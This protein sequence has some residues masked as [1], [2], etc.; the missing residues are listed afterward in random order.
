MNI[1]HRW[2]PLV[3]VG[4]CLAITATTWSACSAQP[5]N[6]L[7][8]SER[9]FNDDPT[10]VLVTS[11]TANTLGFP[12]I[13]SISDAFSG[14]VSGTNRHDFLLS[15]DGGSSAH[16]F[17]I[18]DTFTLE[19]EV[20]LTAGANAPRKEAGLRLNSGIGDAL[21]L[22]N[23]DA[24][25][26]VAF[27]GP[28]FSFGSN[29]GG[30]GYSPGDTILLGLTYTGGGDGVG[31]TPS[32]IEFYIDRLD[33]SGI[34]SSGPL[35]FTNLEGGLPNFTAGLYGQGGTLESTAPGDFLNVVFNDINASVIPE[36]ASATILGLV[37]CV[38]V[39]FVRRR[40]A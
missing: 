27:G 32:T 36:P 21:F 6:G 37:T 26:I 1:T 7:F 17:G 22:V 13:A 14:A 18:D 40:R 3:L 30:N 39:W 25:E 35:P 16:Q 19:A 9:V 15:S 12:A 20:T 38:S 5:I 29:N 34:M 33:G 10:S 28:F 8:T 4:V 2:I 11:N 23:S 24:G 31:G